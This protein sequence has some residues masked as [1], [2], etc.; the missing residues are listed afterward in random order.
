MIGARLSTIGEEELSNIGAD[1]ASYIKAQM[2]TLGSK[3]ESSQ[4]FDA[5]KSFL[6]YRSILTINARDRQA[7]SLS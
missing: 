2:T 1:D 3:Y 7:T 5:N 6:L 4:K